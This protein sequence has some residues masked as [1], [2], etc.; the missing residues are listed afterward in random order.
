MVIDARKQ[1]ILGDVPVKVTN[2]FFW[3]GAQSEFYE[4]NYI[5]FIKCIQFIKGQK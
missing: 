3:I 4:R 5:M 1:N 2:V